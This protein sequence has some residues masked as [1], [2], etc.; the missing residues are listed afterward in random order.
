MQAQA[1]Q[2]QRHGPINANGDAW[3]RLAAASLVEMAAGDKAWDAALTAY[4]GYTGFDFVEDPMASIVHALSEISYTNVPSQNDT[5]RKS[6]T[7][8]LALAAPV[9]RSS[10]WAADDV[11]NNAWISALRPLVERYTGRISPF[12]RFAYGEPF[13]RGPF[14]VDVST[15]AN[16]A[17]FYTNVDPVHIVASPRALYSAPEHRMLSNSGFLA[18][19]MLFHEAGHSVVTTGYGRLGRAIQDAASALHVEE[20]DGLWHAF[21][22]YTAGQAVS[23][24]A[25]P[26]YVMAGDRIGIWSHG[27][28]RY[29]AALSRYWQPYLRRQTTLERAVLAVVRHSIATK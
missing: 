14:R 4:E 19:E 15:F 11:A 8:A 23:S 21:I 26:S 12:L 13:P 27:W 1:R 2:A 22:F 29:R 5:L 28:E 7:D 9:Y 24:V 17:G 18:L 6:L 20:P 16:W 10:R 3:D 25:G